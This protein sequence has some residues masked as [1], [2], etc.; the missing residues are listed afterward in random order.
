MVAAS[1][2]RTF[3][4]AS[5]ADMTKSG[6][7]SSITTRGSTC[8]ENAPHIWTYAWRSIQ[9]GFVAMRLR[10]DTVFPQTPSR[11]VAAGPR[12]VLRSTAPMHPTA[13][14]RTAC[15]GSRSKRSASGRT[16]S[17]LSRCE[18][19]SES[20]S[21]CKASAHRSLQFPTASPRAFCDS[22][23]PAI[24]RRCLFLFS[25]GISRTNAA[26]LLTAPNRT[27]SVSLSVSSKI[28]DK[29]ASA[30]SP[31][32]IFATSCSE[33]ATVRRT[34]HC[35]LSASVAC[36]S[37][38]SCHRARPMASATPGRLNAHA[39]CRDPPD[40][41]ELCPDSARAA[42]TKWS[43]SDADARSPPS[44]EMS[45]PRFSSIATLTW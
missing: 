27:S 30:A 5:S 1:S 33:H 42:L 4:T 37:L 22:A 16:I 24:E 31:P 13:F 41:P 15:A 20:A 26:R 28:G 38:I 18:T 3:G 17:S 44:A 43:T 32:R 8:A 29:S 35:T 23:I 14:A 25:G 12:A 6:T 34:R 2:R 45:G 36:A 39:S 7:S 21:S 40:V 10:S 11:H 9:P 19:I